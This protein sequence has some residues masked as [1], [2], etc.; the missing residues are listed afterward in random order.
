MAG[1]RANGEGTAIKL[2][3]DGR[4]GASIMF[5]GERCYFYGQTQ[6]EVKEKID[7]AKANARKG[8]SVKAA[9]ST[10][11]EW[12]YFWLEEIAKP[13]VTPNTYD[14]Y[15][16]IL[17]IH[18]NPELG[19]HVLS[20]IKPERLIKFFNKKRK[21]KKLSHKKGKD[22]KPIYSDETLS[23]RTVRGIQMVIQLSLSEAVRKKKIPWNPNDSIDKI[24]YKK[25]EVSFLDPD[26]V[27][28]FLEKISGD[29]WF[30][31][32]LV[33]LG[34]GLRAGE[35][36][37][38]KWADYNPDKSYLNVPDTV[39]E[40][41]THSK[42]G[43][44]TTLN[45]Q[46]TKNKKSRIVPLPADANYELQRW[47]ETQDTE[48]EANENYSDRGFIFAWPDG[49][50]VTPGYLSKHFLK[51]IRKYLPGKN[52]HLHSLRH[53]YATMLIE[54]GEDLQVVQENLGH[55]NLATTS[56]IYA[57]VLERMKERAARKLDGFSKRQQPAQT[58]DAA[59]ISDHNFD[60]NAME[61]DRF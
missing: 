27:V 29:R 30:A 21:E 17:R 47:K 26:E 15:E 24:K 12:N 32:F 31:A 55:S 45:F 60:N 18:V 14:F 50:M 53:S 52:I 39:T 4:W 20:K 16:Y 11:E 43:P 19:H 40:I 38:R 58:Q 8:L 5:E 51:L 37:S 36:V 7:E 10:F 44:K 54:K 41:K 28:E 1:K 6:A 23:P 34:S 9:K 49:R 35:L 56:G 46:S 48:K 61:N 25:S 42:E 59:Q 3:S 2:R 57:H 22:G 33:D 13:K